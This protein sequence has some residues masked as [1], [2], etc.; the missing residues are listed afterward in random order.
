MKARRDSSQIDPNDREVSYI[1]HQFP[2]L[3]KD[4]IR[5][6][7]KTHGPDRKAVLNYLDQKSGRRQTEDYRE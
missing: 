5:D 3:S 2:W 7:I 4:E 6:V 1:Q